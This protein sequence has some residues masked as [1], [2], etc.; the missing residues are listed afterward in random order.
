MGG[1]TLSCGIQISHNRCITCTRLRPAETCNNPV[2]LSIQDIIKGIHQNT[3]ER[4]TYVFIYI[5]AYHNIVMQSYW[6]LVS[7]MVS[8]LLKSNV[9]VLYLI[10]LNIAF[11]EYYKSKN[12]LSKPETVHLVM[13]DTPACQFLLVKMGHNSWTINVKYTIIKSDLFCRV[14]IYCV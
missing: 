1:L 10:K 14:K 11:V 12:V 6:L 7:I 2:S 9:L 5:I 3:I 4:T 13:T 8:I